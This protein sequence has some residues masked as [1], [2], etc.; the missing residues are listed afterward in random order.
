M[1]DRSGSVKPQVGAIKDFAH[2]VLSQFKL[3]GVDTPGYLRPVNMA[4]TRFGLV[5]FEATATIDTALTGDRSKVS[6]AIAG[7][8]GS[9]QTCVSCGLDTALKVLNGNNSRTI[10]GNADYDEDV[11]KVI[12]L[13]SDGI[14]TATFGEHG[15]TD[16]EGMCG[17]V[18]CGAEYHCTINGG[19][20][21]CGD[22]AAIDKAFDVRKEGVELFSVGF[23]TVEEQTLDAMVEDPCAV[24]PLA[25]TLPIL[26]PAPSPPPPYAS[27]SDDA[28]VPGHRHCRPLAALRRPCTEPPRRRRR[29][30]RRAA[31]AGLAAAVAAAAVAFAA[32]AVAAA[33]V[34]AARRAGGTPQ[35]PPPPPPPPSSPPPPPP[36]PRPPSPRN[37]I[38]ILCSDECQFGKDGFC[39]DGG[40][41]VE[42]AASARTVRTANHGKTPPSPPP[43]EYESPPPSA[44]S[45]P[46]P[47]APAPCATMGGTARRPPSR[48]TSTRTRRRASTT[49]STAPTAA[50]PRNW[51]GLTARPTQRAL[52]LSAAA[53]APA[54]AAAAGAAA[55][56]RCRRRPRR[57]RR[58]RRRRARRRRRRRRRSRSR[59]SVA[60]AARAAADVVSHVR[61]L[62][63]CAAARRARHPQVRQPERP[64][65]S[66]GGVR[67]VR[68]VHR[69]ARWLLLARGGGDR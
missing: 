8:E 54:H 15:L 53:V 48:A 63:A 3:D 28:L 34:A 29:R 57:R 7:F 49:P 20:D 39:D 52:R 30:R 50:S 66:D 16:D 68:A 32:S 38:V 1:L 58:R 45:P 41:D 10:A 22:K 33:A 27:P 13:V 26:P 42:I 12:F 4:F 31:A 35:S 67:S 2:L 40:D 5:S 43:I 6:D 61:R 23:G 11:R 59:P 9:G 56:R 60:A 47:A 19:T 46:P 25:R 14:Q 21:K 17:Q 44:P 69:G 62:A 37:L 18:R 51:L 24:P 55:H 36:P 65:G 64:S